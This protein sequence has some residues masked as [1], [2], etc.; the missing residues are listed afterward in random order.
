MVG[1]KHLTGEE[2][3]MKRGM[4]PAL[5]ELY[6]SVYRRV[7]Q[8]AEKYE[9]L[10]YMANVFDGYEPLVWIDMAH[11]TPEENRLIAQNMVQV[12]MDRHS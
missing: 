10:H 3:E 7:Q 1:D 11:V 5:A 2:Q 6:E 4:D 9:N 12:I 8:V